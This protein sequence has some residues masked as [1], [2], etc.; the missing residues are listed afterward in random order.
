MTAALHLANPE[1][2]ARIAPMVATFHAGEGVASDSAHIEAALAP[3]LEG[4]PHGCVYLIG[5]RKA[6]IGYAI[7]TFGW[8]VALGG[9]V[10]TLDEF[11]IREGVRGRGIGTEALAAL[12]RT[13]AEAGVKALQL[14]VRD[15]NTQAK[16]LYG[17]RRFVARDTYQVMR[18]VP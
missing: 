13:M 9:L 8:S 16:T 10:G 14:E 6:P 12:Q 7:L 2:L 3:I 11:F 5:P 17:R 18:W 15:E 4:S 1:D